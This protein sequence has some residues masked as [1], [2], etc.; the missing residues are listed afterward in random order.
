MTASPPAGSR[1][2][3]I[4]TDTHGFGIHCSVPPLLSTESPGAQS[5]ISWTSK[6]ETET[7]TIAEE[8]NSSSSTN[9][10]TT[11]ANVPTLLKQALEQVLDLK[12]QSFSKETT[13]LDSSIPPELSKAF[14]ANFFK[15]YKIDTFPGFINVKLMQL[16][17]DIVDIPEISIDPAALVL[18]YSILYHGSLPAPAVMAERGNGIPDR[19]YRCC[20]RIVPSWQRQIAGT[21]TDLITAILVMRASFQQC[22]FKRSWDM[23]K[24]VCQC[25]QTLNMHN[26]DQSLSNTLM[27]PE[28]L[29]DEPDH[30]RQG[31]WALVLVDLFFRLLH[32]KPAIMTA[33]LTEWR[34][35]L[36]W[37]SANPESTEHVVPTLVFIVKSRLTFLL[38]RFF[39]IF[40]QDRK[41]KN[42][43]IKHVTG[44]CTEI[45][46]L[47]EEWSVRDSM[48]KHEETHAYWWM[49][50][51]LLAT[52]Y[53][54]MMM[55]VHKIAEFPSDHSGARR[56][57][58]EASTTLLSVHIARRVMDL[59][60]LSLGRYPSPAAACN[61]FGAFRCCIA[62]G[63]LARHLF[64]SD[65]REPGSTAE[66]DI[67]LLEQVAE[68]MSAISKMDED[69]L[70]LV[71]TL[72]ELN[73]AIHARWEERTGVSP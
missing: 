31:L 3:S 41:D 17:P 60:R 72:Y 21:K 62:Y 43:A 32:D 45:E 68:S 12:R 1:R 7:E 66:T 33:N 19:M 56:V 65:P 47:F 29:S 51:D 53:C 73:R 44:L 54:A 22:D 48:T 64:Q 16:I 28:L 63:Y 69:I 39:E 34:V 36:P 40:D 46:D 11:P 13:Y 42:S 14:I 57:S 38:L 67:K 25:V 35:N 50:Y 2:G 26:I 61:V 18:Y 30:H 37:L 55:M 49:L 23:Y 52:G 10:P 70:P 5:T 20:L 27:N 59:V 24:I 58:E 8:P 6:T 15:H 71:R 9:Y 4:A